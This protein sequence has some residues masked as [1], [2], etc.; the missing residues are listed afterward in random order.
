[1]MVLLGMWEIHTLV[2]LKGALEGVVGKAFLETK[3]KSPQA[4]MIK[5]VT[6]ACA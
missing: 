5:L 3:A 6:L 2:Y 1:M 4:L